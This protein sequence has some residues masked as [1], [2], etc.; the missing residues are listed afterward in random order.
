[1]VRDIAEWLEKL[2]LGQYAKA[3][4]DN[5]VD[6]DLLFELSDEDLV[7]LGITSLGHRKRLFKEI[8][9][10]RSNAPL[11]R[12]LELAEPPAPRP[13]S[14][15][16]AERRQLTVMFCDLVGSTELSGQLDPEDLR[17]VLRR[18]QNAVTEAVSRYGG[19]VGQYL[20]DGVLVYF[21]WPHAYEDQ[22][23]RAVWAGL[24]AIANVR[25]VTLEDNEHLN[26]RVGIAS[27]PVVIGH[28]VDYTGQDI[29]AVTGRTPNLAARL[30]AL[31]EPGQVV[32]DAHTRRLVGTTF[33]LDACGDRALKGF[34]RPVS[35][36]QV[37]GRGQAESRFAASHS[38]SL[39]RFIGRKGELRQ[40]ATHWSLAKKAKGQVVL[41]S[42]EAGIGK[43]RMAQAFWDSIA[44]EECL[45]LSCQCS[46]LHTNSAFYPVIQ[47]L[48]RLAEF[49][50]EDDVESRL[51]KLEGLLG[52]ASMPISSEAPLIAT[53]LSLPIAGRYGALE[54]SPQQIR[55]RTIELLVTLLTNLGQDRPVVF[56]LEDAHWIDP[57][58]ETLIAEAMK[59]IAD[60]SILMV[61]THRPEYTPQWA[62]EPG[63][64]RIE[65][66]R[67]SRE[68][69]VEL[70]RAAGAA[71]QDR[72]VSEIVA[73]ADGVPLYIEE[74]TKSLLES[75]EAEIPASLQA[76][77]VARLDRL[78][79]AAKVAQLA[80]L[81][82]RSFH[83]R[84][85]RAVSELPAAELDRAL[86]A[87]TD[88]E[89]LTQTGTP[90]RAVYAFRHALIQ[91]AAYE[92]LLKSRR[93][94]YHGRTAEVLLRDFANQADAEPEL[95]A[96]HFSLAGELERAVE[97]WLRAGQRAGER[98]AHVEAI[99]HL[100]KGLQ[101]LDRYSDPR[102]RDE[103]ELDLRVAIGTSLGALKGWSSPEVEMNYRRAHLIGAS[104]GST[105]KYSLALSGLANVFLLKGEIG[106]ARELADNELATALEK[107]DMT[108]QL[109]GHRFVGMCSFLAGEFEAARKHLRSGS[110]TYNRS[111]HNVKGYVYSADP[112]VV[113]LS[114]TAWISWFLG[115]FGQAR[116]DIETAL[117]LAGELQHPFGQA[118]AHSLAA[119]VH[120][121]GR[122]PE[123]AGEHANKAIAISEE[124]D[125]PYWLG[126]STVMLGWAIAAVGR[127]DQGLITLERGLEKYEST[128]ARQVRPYI[129]TLMAEMYGWLGE[130]QKGL[131]V[132]EGAYGPGNKTDVRFY[133][134]ESL[135]I[136][137]E[138]LRQLGSGDG[139]ECFD[140]ALI[141]ARRQSAR[142]LELR[143]AMSAARGSLDRRNI[144]SVRTLLA[145]VYRSFDAALGDPDVRDAHE[146]LQSLDSGHRRD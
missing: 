73:R 110:V 55:D 63:V 105:R 36:W 66:H 37:L 19:H 124:H 21:G 82:G 77:L 26:A 112:A 121:A 74:L 11:A 108:L 32:T 95:V 4:A 13:Y 83:Y 28:F 70:V 30:Q 140:R 10:L 14:D 61:I 136:R 119:S 138:L 9:A 133:E 81:L 128:G 98:S 93:A 6:Q 89:L 106:K 90:P 43:S 91:D 1:M 34:P 46:P 51:D 80:A 22:A 24:D 38:G 58:T 126:W 132:L 113:C 27:G 54:L 5:D 53:L 139:R 118:Y 125:F 57:T 72:V 67:L 3:F 29:S 94:R 85:I 31:A 122:N 84:F 86:T 52:R 130:P 129:L 100:Q 127:P 45:R 48:E 134:A 101:E 12:S 87:M 15:T 50:T 143:A 141:L 123:A 79:D 88:S 103:V 17:E 39:S 76:S 62:R 20:G 107:D 92:T 40:L 2:K 115:E 71:L 68:H 78:G 41:L 116:N 104:V 109:R 120:H 99:A 16:D 8:A 114:I 144:V 135:R 56:L 60:A 44:D 96:R 7:K 102:T 117:D 25:N 142:M 18:Y 42:G 131:D 146:L 35:V 75:D 145:D 47:L 137:G 97:Y 69:G 64:G 65:L 49:G 111:A 23:E 33:R 59:R